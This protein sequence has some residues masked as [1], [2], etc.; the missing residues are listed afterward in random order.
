MLNKSGQGESGVG[1]AAREAA[2]VT[3]A[4]RKKTDEGKMRRFLGH[5][6]A[7]MVVDPVLEDLRVDTHLCLVFRELPDCWNGVNI[8]TPLLTHLP[9]PVA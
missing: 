6:S 1:E 7:G 5:C 2:G 8:Q 9:H 3:E 4:R